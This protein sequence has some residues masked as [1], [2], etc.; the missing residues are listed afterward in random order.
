MLAFMIDPVAAVCHWGIPKGINLRENTIHFPPHTLSNSQRTTSQKFC[1][2]S[3]TQ[4]PVSKMPSNKAAGVKKWQISHCAINLAKQQGILGNLLN[5]QTLLDSC[6]S[7]KFTVN[8][9]PLK[10]LSSKRMPGPKRRILCVSTPQQTWKKKSVGMQ[11]FLIPIP[12]IHVF[13]KR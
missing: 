2:F 4:K 9:I 7:D 10:L 1:R 5:H 3:G 6:W 13:R 11:T 8:K 12:E